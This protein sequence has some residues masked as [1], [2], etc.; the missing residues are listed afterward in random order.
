MTRVGEERVQ[1]GGRV[2]ELSGSWCLKEEAEESWCE[3]GI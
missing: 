2:N 1:M 3:S